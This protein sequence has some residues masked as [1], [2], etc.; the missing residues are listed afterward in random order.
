MRTV[1]LRESSLQPDPSALSGV[2]TLGTI[3]GPLTAVTADDALSDLMA[4]PTRT[5]AEALLVRQQALAHLGVLAAG[6][7]AD[8][9]R[10][11]VIAPPALWDPAA[12]LVSPLLRATR[13][14]AWLQPVTLDGLL[15]GPRSPRQ[16]ESY[17]PEAKRAEISPEALAA[18]AREQDR[19]GALAAI[20]DDPSQVVEPFGQALLRAQSR[21]WRVESRTGAALVTSIRR[22]LA[23]RTD[24]VHVLSRGSIVFSGDVGAV[25]VTIE[26]DLDSA[27]TVGVQLIGEPA[28]RLSSAPLEGIRIEAGHR[29]SVDLDA[30]VI[31]GDPL[32]ARVQLLTP[33]GERYG[34]PSRVTLSSTA[35]ARAASWVVIAAFIAIA[36]FVVVGVVRRIR[37]ARA[38]H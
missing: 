35:Y 12:R 23:A 6:A 1:V 16:R 32:T 9:P 18:V 8:E 2:G 27:V 21:A 29:V 20:L 19:L 10:R 37:K 24:A 36:V 5:T 11:V 4:V 22:E 33:E 28:A 25:P 30:R 13:T 15:D 26:N 34:M 7:T 38:A 17:G 14:A 31:G 3:A